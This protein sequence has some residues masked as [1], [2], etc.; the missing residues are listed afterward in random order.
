MTTTADAQQAPEPVINVSI[1]R[2]EVRA[3]ASAPAPQRS[4]PAANRLSL[5][6]YL[7]RRNGKA[8]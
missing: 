7:G 4:R 3:V 5:D 6:D 8:R 2:I 1:G